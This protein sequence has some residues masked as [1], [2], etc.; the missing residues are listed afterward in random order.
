MKVDLTG[1]RTHFPDH[2]IQSPNDSNQLFDFPSLVM[3]LVPQ[4]PVL[5]A[6]RVK[7]SSDLY[8]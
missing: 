7:L 4:S 5:I 3:Q 1:P 8:K 2:V 6:H